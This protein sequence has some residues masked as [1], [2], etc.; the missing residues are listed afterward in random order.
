MTAG[1]GPL[2]GCR[3][4]HRLGTSGIAWLSRWGFAALV[5]VGSALAVWVGATVEVPG[6][7]PSYALEA[8]P[9]Y[10]LEVGAA[11]FAAVYVASLAFVLALGNRGFTE[12]SASGVKADDLYGVRGDGAIDRYEEMLNFLAAQVAELQAR[13]SLEERLHEE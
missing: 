4:T 6:E 11:V 10:R 9:I 5:T 12:L 1:G 2:Y 3:V 13:A 7:L 8:A